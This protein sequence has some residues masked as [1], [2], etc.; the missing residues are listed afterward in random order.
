MT[1]DWISVA[2]A[3][4]AGLGVIALALATSRIAT[5]VAFAVAAAFGGLAAIAAGA[6]DAGLV[7]I[8]AGALIALMTMASAAPIGE[9]ASASHR[10]A[11]LPLAACAVFAL[12][13][14]LA[15]LNAPSAPTLMQATR[16]VAFDAPRG[17]D[18]F[19]AL[20]AFAVI[21]AG[22][23]GLIGFGERG[24]FGPDKDGAS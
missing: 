18:I 14:M 10:P 17:M 16:T 5:A 20:A 22:V 1:A 15:W 9:V 24:L 12:V 4:I 7:V 19:I 6:F 23:V 2:A 13:I 21:G 8:G 11:L 3:L